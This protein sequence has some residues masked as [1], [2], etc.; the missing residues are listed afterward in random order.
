MNIILY[1]WWFY[2]LEEL[3]KDTFMENLNK[4]QSNSEEG[5]KSKEINEQMVEQW[6]NDILAKIEDYN[7]NEMK[8]TGILLKPGSI[9]DSDGEE[10]LSR[11]QKEPR[12]HGLKLELHNFRM[13]GLGIRA[14]W[15]HLNDDD[16]TLGTVCID[17]SDPSL[18]YVMRRGIE[19][20]R[21]S[22][23]VLN[24]MRRNAE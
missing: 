13:D 20:P 11:L 1:I 2:L 23:E 22:E 5:F 21:V 8:I 17:S 24:I 18:R 3:I 19:S 7:Q 12:L 16:M 15:D 14:S 4:M 10:L 9:S 6:T